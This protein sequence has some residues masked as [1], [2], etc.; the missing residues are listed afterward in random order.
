MNGTRPTACLGQRFPRLRP[1]RVTPLPRERRSPPGELGTD[2]RKRRPD[3]PDRERPD[4]ARSTSSGVLPFGDCGWRG[5][6]RRGEEGRPSWRRGAGATT[7]PDGPRAPLRPR[8]CE[9]DRA[10]RCIGVHQQDLGPSARPLSARSEL[11]NQH[12]TSIPERQLFRDTQEEKETRRLRR[13]LFGYPVGKLADHI[14]PTPQHGPNRLIFSDNF[15]S[16]VWETVSSVTRVSLATFVTPPLA[17][18]NWVQQILHKEDSLAQRAPLTFP[19][20]WP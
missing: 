12:P 1:R 8:C 16:V 10:S 18:T 19:K 2:S 9:P 20:A 7:R 13:L 17:P 3:A 5:G 15:A 6:P 11:P 14:E 4:P